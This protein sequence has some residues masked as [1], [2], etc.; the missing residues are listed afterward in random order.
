MRRMVS[1]LLELLG[2][3]AVG[4]GLYLIAPA[5]LIVVGGVLLWAVAQVLGEESE[6]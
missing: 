2:F 1:E 5:S 3:A 6:R 4:V